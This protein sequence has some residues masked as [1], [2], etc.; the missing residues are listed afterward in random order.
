MFRPLYHCLSRIRRKHWSINII[1][2]LQCYEE[3]K[4]IAFHN[5]SSASN[6]FIFQLRCPILV[7]SE[8]TIFCTTI[9]Y[10]NCIRFLDKFGSLINC[11]LGKII[12]FVFLLYK[13]LVAILN[14]A[15][16]T[17]IF[18]RFKGENGYIFA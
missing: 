8:D 12:Y 17:I 15:K 7:N 5:S 4:A 14:V 18:S 1:I 6:N 3:V 13:F 2:L 10:K 11:V 16:S 9:S